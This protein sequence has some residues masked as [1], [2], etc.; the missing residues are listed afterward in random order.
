M[1][2]SVK[3]CG[4]SDEAAVEA[5]VEGGA[6]M[7]G[8]V[9][10]DASPRHVTPQRAQEL[11]KRVPNGIVKVAW[12]RGRGVPAFTFCQPAL[13]SVRPGKPSH[14]PPAPSASDRPCR[15]QPRPLSRL[16]SGPSSGRSNKR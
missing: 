11:T 12:G 7:T 6:A 13:H 1:T 16:T 8:F 5:A 4:L 10:F 14:P 2:I 3:I 15:L 9:F